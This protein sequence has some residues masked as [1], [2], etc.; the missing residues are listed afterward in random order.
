MIGSVVHHPGA[1][2]PPEARFEEIDGRIRELLAEAEAAGVSERRYVQ[3]WIEATRE[4]L[5]RVELPARWK[6]GKRD[7][8]GSYGDGRARKSGLVGKLAGLFARFIRTLTPAFSAT[9]RSIA[10][11]LGLG[12]N[13]GPRRVEAPKKFPDPPGTRQVRTFL[14]QLELAGLVEIVHRCG[15]DEHGRP[16]HEPGESQASVYLLRLPREVIAFL[17]RLRCRRARRLPLQG[18]RPASSAAAEADATP[19]TE[20]IASRPTSPRSSRDASQAA[21][22]DA[23]PSAADDAPSWWL[24]IAREMHAQRYPL[25][26]T[27]TT[28]VKREKLAI[29]ENTLEGAAGWCFQELRKRGVEELPHEGQ[30]RADLARATFG[31]WLEE[32]RHAREDHPF[33]WFAGDVARLAPLAGEAWVRA[34]CRTHRPAPREA[35]PAGIAEALLRPAEEGEAPAE[36]DELDELRAAR[37]E[38]LAPPD[39]RTI[40]AGAASLL[41]QQEAAFAQGRQTGA[42]VP[43]AT[44]GTT[45]APDA[46]IELE[47]PDEDSPSFKPP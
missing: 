12:H 38:F 17:D 27:S 36:E 8:E 39:W 23:S 3:T 32:P 28:T 4:I 11:A 5:F 44:R 1:A 24:P 13:P 22:G 19:P 37:A 7:G 26:K 2:W 43:R 34:W 29:I 16:R 45:A 9:Q 15:T 6:R 42:V 14:R 33:G 40:E 35:L 20:S 21:L 10:Y 25:A 30:V 41:A 46:T 31:A 47:E 18:Q